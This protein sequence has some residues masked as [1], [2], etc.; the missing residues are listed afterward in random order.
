MYIA[1]SRSISLTH[2][3][4]APQHTAKEKETKKYSIIMSTT[5]CPIN[6]FTFNT[7]IYNKVNIIYHDKNYNVSKLT[8]HLSAEATPVND[9]MC[10]IR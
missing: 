7:H 3:R 6:L 5:A 10:P 4:T 2:T 1:P 9:E 8:V